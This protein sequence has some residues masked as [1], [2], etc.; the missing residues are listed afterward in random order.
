VARLDTVRRTV[1][2]GAGD[3][4]AEVVHDRVRVMDGER[5]V[6]RF[7][8]VEVEFEPDSQTLA[9]RLVR[10]LTEMGGTVDTTPKY[11][12]ALRALG[13]TPPPVAP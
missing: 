13:H 10:Y 2:A 12:R 9:D 4:R 8:E 1:D 5:E 7:S 11:V 3:E 6:E